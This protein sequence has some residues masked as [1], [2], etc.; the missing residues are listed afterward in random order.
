MRQFLM[1]GDDANRSENPAD[2]ICLIVN[3]KHSQEVNEKGAVGATP[4]HGKDR[5]SEVRMVEVSP[6]S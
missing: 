4:S 5:K 6:F 1:H 3:A 2:F